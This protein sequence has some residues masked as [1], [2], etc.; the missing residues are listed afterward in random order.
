MSIIII[1]KGISTSDLAVIDVKQR[2][3]KAVFKYGEIPKR[4]TDVELWPKSSNLLCWSCD[5]SVIGYPKFIPLNA[6][7]I[8]GND[9]CNVMG[10][11]DK[12]ACALSYANAHLPKHIY[13]DICENIR[14]F[15]QKF[16]SIT[17]DSNTVP[18]PNKTLM[19]QY[20]GDSGITNDEFDALIMKNNI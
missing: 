5:R 2:P 3:Q 6:T 13:W 15:S 4:F 12:W 19:K 1:V 7:V 9:T 20:C 17:D 18:A 10:N 16:G 14:T 8:K 11:F